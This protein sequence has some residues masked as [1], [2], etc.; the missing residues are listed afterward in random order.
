MIVVEE[1]IAQLIINEEE[2]PQDSQVELVY[3][4]KGQWHVENQIFTTGRY[5]FEARK[6]YGI[7]TVFHCFVAFPR[8]EAISHL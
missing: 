5:L 1:P 3:V 4:L 6:K 7:Y 2:T 8:V